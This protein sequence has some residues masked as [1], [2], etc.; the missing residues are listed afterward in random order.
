LVPDLLEYIWTLLLSA[1]FSK[2][3]V[4]L[5]NFSQ[6]VIPFPES[7]LF[8]LRTS[9]P[10]RLANWHS[11][12]HKTTIS[13]KRKILNLSCMGLNSLVFWFRDLWSKWQTRLL[14]IWSPISFFFYDNHKYTVIQI[15]MKGSASVSVQEWVK[16]KILVPSSLIPSTLCESLIS[17]LYWGQLPASYSDPM[18][19]IWE[20]T[21]WVH[22]N[23][24]AKIKFSPHL[25][26]NTSSLSCSQSL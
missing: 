2:R 26:L 24:D 12:L 3:I 19:S 20:G 6:G 21:V 5:A 18:V 25:G 1:Y 4:L 22:W 17:V 13:M 9:K 16:V 23:M 7:F 14:P 8:G 11:W 15:Q 10:H